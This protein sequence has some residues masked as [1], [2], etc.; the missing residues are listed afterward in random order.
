MFKAKNKNKEKTKQPMNLREKLLVGLLI[1]SSVIGGYLMLRVKEQ[2]TQREIWKEMRDESRSD[3]KQAKVKRMG[4]QDVKQLKKE[5]KTLKN[6]M[7]IIEK[8]VLGIEGGFID[9]HSLKAVANMRSKLTTLS[10]KHNLRLASVSK[11]ELNLSSFAGATQ[12]KLSDFLKR[13]T[14]DITLY[15]SYHDLVNFIAGLETLPN[16]VVVTKISLSPRGTAGSDNTLD[17]NMIVSF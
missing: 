2:T 3:K 17:I 12:S 15:G 5:I 7:E 13:P 8:T 4:S 10:G 16:R 9:L 6:E 14:F 1:F 11:A